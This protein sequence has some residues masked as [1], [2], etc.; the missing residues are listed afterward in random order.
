MTFCN[1]IETCSADREPH[2]SVSDFS[3]LELSLWANISAVNSVAV[4]RTS[5]LLSFKAPAA[6]LYQKLLWILNSLIC[7][8]S[9]SSTS[10]HQH[11]WYV[12]SNTFSEELTVHMNT[13]AFPKKKKHR[14]LEV[15]KGLGRNPGKY[16]YG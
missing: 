15:V 9:K 5:L 6:S 10:N 4:R 12:F 1:D 8:T 13:F 16:V 11:V 14:R 7:W 2:R 3:D